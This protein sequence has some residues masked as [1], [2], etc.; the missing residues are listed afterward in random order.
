MQ[1]SYVASTHPRH[2]YLPGVSLPRDLAAV[3]LFC[4]LG[5]TISAAWISYVGAD[6]IGPFLLQLE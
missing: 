2:A 6:V 3:V 1:S 5:L 4:L